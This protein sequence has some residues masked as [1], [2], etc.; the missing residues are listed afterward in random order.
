MDGQELIAEQI[1]HLNAHLVT[2]A[3]YL[4]A[5]TD[6]LRRANQRGGGESAPR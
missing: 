1:K 3:H 5:I 4:R 2:L 6:E